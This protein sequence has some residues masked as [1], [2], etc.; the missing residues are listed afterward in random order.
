MP[1]GGGG[2]IDLWGRRDW[3]RWGILERMIL[4]VGVGY[5]RPGGQGGE[6][7]FSKKS[8]YFFLFFV[9]VVFGFLVFFCLFFLFFRFFDF[10]TFIFIIFIFSTVG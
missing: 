1:T 9:F 8:C 4:V 2:A 7:S 6:K 10:G 5:N 3:S